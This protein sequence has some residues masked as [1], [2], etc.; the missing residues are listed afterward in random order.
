MISCSLLLSEKLIRLSKTFH[1]SPI[2]THL[3]FHKVGP[4]SQGTSGNIF[5]LQW[6]IGYHMLSG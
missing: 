3:A 5:A 4:T 2:S 1:N 6:T